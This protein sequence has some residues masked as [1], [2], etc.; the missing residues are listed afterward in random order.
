[1]DDRQAQKIMKMAW[2]ETSLRCLLW[3]LVKLDVRHAGY[4]AWP[5]NIKLMVR[6]L[7]KKC[8][9]IISVSVETR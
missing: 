4:R 5:D 6:R 2:Q 8:A 9:V 1:M 3:L 7:E